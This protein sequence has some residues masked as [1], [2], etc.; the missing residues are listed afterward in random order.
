M[1]RSRPLVRRLILPVVLAGVL[2]AGCGSPDGEPSG[3]LGTSAAPAPAVVRVPEEAPTITE[4]V[5]RVA[6]GG[7]VLV[8]PG[9][10]EEEVRITTPDVTLRGLDRNDTVIDGGGTRSFGV[11]GAADGVRVENLTVRSALF[12]G[13]LVTSVHGE[14]GPLAHGGP[15]YSRLDPE[16]FP[17]LE[18]FAVSHVTASNNGLYG[19]YA[20][21]ARHG[22]I[23]DSY[24]S[25]SADSGI[26]VG[27]CEE[28]DVLVTGNVAERNAVGFENANASDSVVVAG[29]RFSGNRIGMTLLS[30]YQEAFTPQRANTVVGNLVADNTSAESPAHALGGFGIGV[31]ITGGQANELA[32]NRIT[33]NPVAGVQLGNAEDIAAQDNRF[34]ANA[35][36]SNGVDLHDTSA[37]RTPSS[38]T[39]VDPAGGEGPAT[40]LPSALLEATCP[41]GTG[42]L[43]GVTDGAPAVEVPPGTSFLDVPAPPEQPSM[44]D[45]EEAPERLPATVELP[46]LAGFPL[47]GPDLLADRAGTAA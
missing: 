3:S 28:C 4:A 10:Y 5:E 13:V 19:I 21:N 1:H 7:L 44:P 31:G 29:N 14:D 25:G 36:G 37:Q 23:T 20:F 26:Y 39:C 18:R 17:P 9:V 32:R 46:D 35:F 27:Q 47:P 43:V 30:S 8:G 24:A 11:V 12:Y 22:S 40:A 2:L 16:E 38:G 42:P 6:E 45:P 33:G 41:D 34:V 15:G